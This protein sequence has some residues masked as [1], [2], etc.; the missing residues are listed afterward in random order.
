[1]CDMYKTWSMMDYC[2]DGEYVDVN[3]SVGF[4]LTR[5]LEF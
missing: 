3:L 5:W 1:M 4:T 2:W